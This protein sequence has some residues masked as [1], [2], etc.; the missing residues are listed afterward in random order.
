MSGLIVVQ[1]VCVGY[2]QKT[3]ICQWQI[4]KLPS[5]ALLLSIS[6]FGV[7]Q[8]FLFLIYNV[9]AGIRKALVRLH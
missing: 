9:S 8:Q 4:A 7:R 5:W 6:V 1:T 2:L 3:L